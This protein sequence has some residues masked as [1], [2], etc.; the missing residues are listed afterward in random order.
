MTLKDDKNYTF[1]KEYQKYFDACQ[2]IQ[3]LSANLGL[4]NYY[5]VQNTNNN[6]SMHLQKSLIDQY[7]KDIDNPIINSFLGTE[8]PIKIRFSIKKKCG[9][10]NSKDVENWKQ[11]NKNSSILKRKFG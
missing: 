11:K 4:N 5:E 8:K 6:F 7:Q 9:I 1:Y 3:N 10:I 2:S